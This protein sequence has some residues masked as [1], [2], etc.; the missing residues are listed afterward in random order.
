ME[1]AR[2]ESPVHVRCGTDFIALLVIVAGA[3]F[4]FVPRSPLWL[5]G[6]FRLLAF[7]FVAAIAYEVMRAA[8]VRPRSFVSRMLTWPGRALQ[9]ITTRE[10]ADDQLE[11]ALA[12]LAG[13]LEPRA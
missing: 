9:L 4:A 2:R 6:A 3:V 13:S 1:E 10:P 11:I 5:G 8:A 7:P 12:A